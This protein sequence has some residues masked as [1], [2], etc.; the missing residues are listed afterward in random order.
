MLAHQIV[1]RRLDALL[2][3][4][5][6]VVECAVV[7]ERLPGPVVVIDDQDMVVRLAAT[8]IHMTH[9]N[10]VRVRVHPLREQVAQ[11]V[12][13]LHV[14]R[15]L[16]IELV[17]AERLAVVQCFDI[18]LGVLRERLSTASERAGAS[19]HVARDRD[20]ALVLLAPDV[21]LR[22]R[23]AGTRAVVRGAHEAVRSPSSSRTSRSSS[24]SSGTSAESATGSPARARRSRSLTLI[25]SGR[26]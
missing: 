6:A 18:P 14:L 24:I 20:S 26:T 1:V 11:I 5:L 17:V 16:R 8:S 2:V 13:P 23:G 22:V 10:A 21:A 3:P 9:N 19:R 4:G 7:R 15:V 25:A 12:H